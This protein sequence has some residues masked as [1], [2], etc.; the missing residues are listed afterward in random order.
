MKRYLL[1][2]TLAAVLAL[3]ACQTAPT[4]PG[5]TSSASTADGIAKAIQE[6]TL[7]RKAFTQLAVSKTI[8]WAQDDA[9]QAALTLIRQNLDKAQGLSLSNPAQAEQL[10]A[11]ALTALAAYQGAQP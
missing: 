2:L 6:V 8:T 4:A 7:A 5:Q 9:A 10:L 11:D 1:T 3:P